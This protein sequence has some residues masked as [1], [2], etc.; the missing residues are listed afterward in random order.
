MADLAACNRGIEVNPRAASHAM[1]AAPRLLLLRR[2]L[3]RRSSGSAHQRRALT[4]GPARRPC[5]S[6]GS[7]SFSGLEEEEEF[8]VLDAESGT[9]RCAANYARLTP[10]SFIERAAAVYGDRPAVVYGETW[11]CTWSEV[12]ERCLRVAAAL[13]TRF[14][15]ARGD[16]VA[17]L[18]PNVPA[19]YELHFSVPM[20]GAILC[21][22]NTRHDAAMVSALL[23]HS[24]AKVLLVE[25]GLLDVGR[26]ALNNLASDESI[27][28]G[29]PVLITILDDSD[30]IISDYTDYESL[31][32]E[33]PSLF[34]IRWPL[35]ELDPI[36]LN[37]M[38]GTTARPKGVIYSHQGAYLNTLATVLTYNISTSLS[39][40]LTCGPC[41]CSTPMGGTYHGAS[42]CRA[43]PTSACAASRQRSSLIR[44]HNTR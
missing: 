33:T 15:V 40:R 17:V 7:S 29:L 25:S 32:R 42:P 8:E 26:A 13:A 1:R 43:A 10:L 16:V 19:M 30:S 34:N 4:F 24:G 18:S 11:S 12:R 3:P 35:N 39:R 44:S 27:A 6:Q 20:A 5:A 37:Y 14:G 28:T 9:V 36:A 31:I 2:P 41:R 22:L 23:K 38:S 21:T